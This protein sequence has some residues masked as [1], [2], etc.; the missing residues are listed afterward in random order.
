MALEANLEDQSA[1]QS[2]MLYMATSQ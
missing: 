1:T 2:G